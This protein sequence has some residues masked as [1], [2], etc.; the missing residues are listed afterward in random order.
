MQTGIECGYKRRPITR[1]AV[2]G[3]EILK[4]SKPSLPGAT[5]LCAGISRRSAQ[6]VPDQ[7]PED[8]YIAP[9]IYSQPQCST[10]YPSTSRI[11]STTPQ[12]LF[13]LVGALPMNLPLFVP[14]HVA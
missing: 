14:C 13:L 3:L 9:V 6:N 8:C 10:A 12:V 1:Q 4:S 7:M 5:S 11:T 2:M